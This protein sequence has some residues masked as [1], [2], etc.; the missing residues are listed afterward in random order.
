ML[1]RSILLLVWLATSVFAETSL[2]K[3]T[4]GGKTLYIG[5]TVHMLRSSD[6][7]LPQAYEHAFEA[8]DV[9][10][11]ETDMAAVN[12][13][14]F[15]LQVQQRLMFGP[16]A[17]LKDVLSN[18]TYKMLERYAAQNGISMQRFDRMKPQ[19]AAITIANLELLRIGMDRPG[20]DLFYFGRASQSGKTVRWFEHAEEQVAMLEAMG[21]DDEDGMVRQSLES[22]GEYKNMMDA[23][24]AAWRKGD[25]LSLE[26]LGKKY[27]MHESPDDYRRLIVERN[28]R[29]M[30]KL[31]QMLRSRETE[32]VL[33]GALHLVGEAGLIHQLKRSGYRVEQL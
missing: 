6:Y 17:R 2:W 33:V 20:V 28:R 14:Q 16:D 21:R 10:V 25:S 24:L 22:V 18:N 7:P 9:V 1:I 30:V 12:S 31:K 29:W 13:P 4:Y 27:L 26:R 15:A 19:M 32:L 11:F 3:V 5:G 23:M 8:A